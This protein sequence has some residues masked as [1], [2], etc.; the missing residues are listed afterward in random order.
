[1][2]Q[3]SY[4]IINKSNIMKAFTC[5]FYFCAEQFWVCQNFVLPKLAVKTLAIESR[6]KLINPPGIYLAEKD[7]NKFPYWG[8]LSSDPF[9][10]T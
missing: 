8:P 1:M 10:R 7:H 3:G 5:K 6:V 4:C 2:F 9:A